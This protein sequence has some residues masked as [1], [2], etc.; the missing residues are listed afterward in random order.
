M[1]AR[2][3]VSSLGWVKIL[4]ER[5]KFGNMCLVIGGEFAWAKL[6]FDVM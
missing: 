4:R 2:G 1:G 5:D 6:V 3:Q